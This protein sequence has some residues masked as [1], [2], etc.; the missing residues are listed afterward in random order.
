MRIP[1]STAL[2]PLGHRDFALAL[3]RDQIAGDFGPLRPGPGG[4]CGGSACGFMRGAGPETEP[5]KQGKA[6]ECQLHCAHTRESPTDGVLVRQS[7]V[8][9]QPI[10]GPGAGRLQMF[11]ATSRA[12]HGCIPPAAGRLRRRSSALA[13]A[14]RKRRRRIAGRLSARDRARVSR[15]GWHQSPRRRS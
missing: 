1:R 2:I 13:D 12:R 9:S 4:C 14:S 3:G 5:N 8:H 7:L 10:R 11:A 6:K 15:N